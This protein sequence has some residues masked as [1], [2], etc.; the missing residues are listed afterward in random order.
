MKKRKFLQDIVEKGLDNVT[1]ESLD[2]LFSSPIDITGVPLPLIKIVLNSCAQGIMKACYDDIVSRRLSKREVDKH[3]MVFRIAEQE[4]FRL[5]VLNH[6][7]SIV[8]FSDL[9]YK[10]AFEVAE[11]LSL[12]AMK[13]CEE[14]K[15]KI[16]GK[17]YGRQFYYANTR[18]DDMHHIISL[19]GT[20]SLRQI[21]M[22][23][24]II[25]GFNNIDKELYITNSYA[26]VEINVLLNYGIWSR[27]KLPIETN[28]THTIQIKTLLPTIA[29]KDIY[30]SLSLEDIPIIEVEK[31]MKSLQLSTR[32]CDKGYELYVGELGADAAIQ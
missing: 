15:I 22:I 32:G 30:N 1:Q 17:Y 16:L 9:D 20:L 11:H 18:W 4:Y 27:E 5:A 2:L 31:V 25:E 19:V 3:N 12:E 7:N 10:Y 8:D 6:C 23:K 26:C 21:I 28:N 29:A 13:Q 24:L 14:E